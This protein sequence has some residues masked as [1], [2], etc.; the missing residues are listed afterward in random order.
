M[1][2]F[3]GGAV[4]AF[5]ATLALAAA[6]AA[7]PAHAAA[8]PRVVAIGDI[9]GAYE[10]L[11]ALLQRAGLVDAQLRWSGQSATLVQVG[12]MI[13]RGPKSRAVM[14]LLMSLQSQAS[15][16]GGRVIV[17][18]GNHEAM[19]MFGDRR[20]VS[21][22][23]Y[24]GFADGES[25]HRRATAY[26]A[27]RALRPKANA[28]RSAWMAGHPLGFVERVAALGPDGK[29]GKWL[30][31]LPAVVVIGDTLFAHGGISPDFRAWK[32]DHFNDAIRAEIRTFDATKRTLIADRLA[33]PTDS[34]EELVAAASLPAA[35]MSENLKSLLDF[36]HWLSVRDEGPLWFRG[37]ATWT[38]EE[39][40]PIVDRLIGTFA[41]K[42][43]VVGHSAQTGAIARRFGDRVFLI[44][45]GMLAAYFPNGRASAL[46][47]DS[48]RV[49]TLYEDGAK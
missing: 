6:P 7:P 26:D 43:I 32:T 20:Y 15:R 33:L 31:A 21:A 16:Q 49:S 19:N 22:A 37:Y 1:T 47:I 3:T 44:D 17:L 12:D 25:E 23:D 34:I 30:R 8:V 35:R 2:R 18:L 36:D 42:R 14:D 5:A 27:A 40:G 24:A 13:D 28:D 4:V 9:H 10:A 45:T 38:D 41:V 11:A 39:G 46:I 48:G 29:Y